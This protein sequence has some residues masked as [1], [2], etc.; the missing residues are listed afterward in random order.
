M[1]QPLRHDGRSPAQLRPIQITPHFLRHPA[2]SVL[3]EQGLTKVICSA[4][5]EEKVPPF[6]QS[7][8]SGWITAEYAMLP[9]A[10]NVRTGRER[11]KVGGRTMEIQR[12]IGRSLRAVLDLKGLGQRTLTID[13]DV[14][15]ADGGTRTASITG[16]YVAL[17]LALAKLKAD[18]LIAEIPVREPVAAISAGKIGGGLWLDLDYGDDSGA[19]VDANFVMTASGALIEVQGTAEGNPFSRSEL[20]GLLDLAWGGIQELVQIQKTAIERALA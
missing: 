15:Q 20:D 4:S 3:I 9:G 16:G 13:C 12:L 2:G 14:I 17:Y 8:G 10:T 7:S 6:L 1:T 19:E 18:G 11:S 5:I